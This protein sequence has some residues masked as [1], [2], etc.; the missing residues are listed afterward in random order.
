ML[1]LADEAGTVTIVPLAN[2]TREVR[3][4]ARDPSVIVPHSPCT[5]RYSVELVRRIFAAY[6][7]IFTCDE[8]SRDIDDTEAALDVQYSVQAHFKQD[9]FMRPLKILDY[10]CGAGSSTLTLSRLFPKAAAIRG[11]DFVG[12]F[13]DIARARMAHYG[14]ANVEFI[15][16]PSG[17]AF[18]ADRGEYDLVFLNAV[19]EHLLPLERP[20]VLATIWS[21]LK[22]GGALILNQTPH[23]WF[24]IETHTS[25]LPLINYL[26]AAAAHRAV[27]R[28]S[29]RQIRSYSWEQLLR[30]GV[31]GATVREIMGHIGKID[32]RARRLT[33]S[34]VSG[35]WA[36][37]W[38]AAKRARLSKVR[39]PLMRGGILMAEWLVSIT[40]L[41]LAPYISI[42]VRKRKTI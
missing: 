35:S 29:K 10:G 13:L 9:I 26:P 36:G 8:I 5:S 20:A 37:I 40:R 42:A 16:V 31:R 33:P 39:Q 25:G 32:P 34:R 21:A 38:Y 24:P 15:N 6:G 28:F 22:P 41:P 30:A 18:A 27:R 1:S 7:S 19:Y 12:P 11:V 3:G 2:G 14:V 4:E 23:R 17:G